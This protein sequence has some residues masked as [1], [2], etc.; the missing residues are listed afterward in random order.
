MLTLDDIR[1][2][3][4]SI[5]GFAHPAPPEALLEAAR[6]LHEIEGVLER[7]GVVAVLTAAERDALDAALGNT[8]NDPDG[9]EMLKDSG[10]RRKLVESARRGRRKLHGIL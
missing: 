9:I 7:G 8:M 6:K 5:A 1:T 4:R 3:R 2:L 10:G